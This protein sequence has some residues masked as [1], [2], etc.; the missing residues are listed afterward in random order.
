MGRSGGV[1]RD[2]MEEVMDPIAKWILGASLGLVA[3][4]YWLD[5]RLHRRH[6]ETI[7]HVKGVRIRLERHA[8]ESEHEAKKFRLSIYQH[9]KEWLQSM[10]G[11]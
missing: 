1:G 2:G 3:V 5:W 6:D 8:D 9:F 10:S 11:K 7:N 4:I